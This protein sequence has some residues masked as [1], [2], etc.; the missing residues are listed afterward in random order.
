MKCATN[1]K[2]KVISELK[3]NGAHRLTKC[4][5]RCECDSNNFIEKSGKCIKKAPSEEAKVK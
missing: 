4:F 5:L 2:F 1:M 3:S